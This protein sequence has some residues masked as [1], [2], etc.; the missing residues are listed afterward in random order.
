MTELFVYL[1]ESLWAFTVLAV[2]LGLL[3]G[4]FLNV[5]VYRLPIMMERGWRMQC[6]EYLGN[7]ELPAKETKIEE[8]FNLVVPRSRCPHCGHVISA[9]ENIPVISYLWL[10]GRCAECGKPISARYPLV[11]LST[12]LLSGITAWHFGFGWTAG[13]ALLFTWSLI[14][15]TLIDYDHQLLPD[16][17]T[18]PFLWIGLLLSL[19]G[20]FTDST[21]SIVGAIA[22]YLSLWSVYILFK[23]A[24]G[25]EGMG[26][27]D[28]KLLAMLGAWL[29][30][31]ALP[32]I[33]LLSSV[34]GAAVGITL[35]LFK[36]RDKSIPIPFGPY[37]ATAGWLALLWGHEITQRYFA[38]LGSIN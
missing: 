10:R 37:L 17:I 21:S 16:D 13:A 6:Q 27:G 1:D 28:F 36:G 26:Y 23:W 35:I 5:V 12:A 32:V 19:F 25:K 29:G 33:I 34:V 7:S 2:V 4:S 24:T 18:L 11:E 31:Q 14:A 22:G 30:W 9:L 8:P 3:I 20:L 15:L 38:L